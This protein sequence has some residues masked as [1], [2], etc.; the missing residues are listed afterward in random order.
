MKK[1]MHFSFVDENVGYTM[2]I[3][4]VIANILNIVYNI[5][6]IV[7]TCKTRSTKDLSGWFIFLRIIANAIWVGYSIEV[8]STM[9][10]INNLISVVSSMI[11]GWFILMNMYAQAPEEN[12]DESFILKPTE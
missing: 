7:K 3:F 8:E 12:D 11:I 10:L 5:P 1:L 4:L 9:M 6:Q 2:N